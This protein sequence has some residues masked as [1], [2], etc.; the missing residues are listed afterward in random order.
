MIINQY[1]TLDWSTEDS[2]TETVGIATENLD[3]NIKEHQIQKLRF[4][5]QG[6]LKEI[7]LQDHNLG[8]DKF[9]RS[10]IGQIKKITRKTNVSFEVDFFL[11][12]SEM[13]EVFIKIEINLINNFFFQRNLEIVQYLTK[14]NLI[15]TWLQ[16]FHES[17]KREDIELTLANM[18]SEGLRKKNKEKVLKKQSK[19]QLNDKK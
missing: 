8:W 5:F 10:L 9:F 14:I 1:V 15:K 4:L 13:V 11:G 19:K 7:N 16:R 18:I 6:N 12:K 3:K 17:S 2:L